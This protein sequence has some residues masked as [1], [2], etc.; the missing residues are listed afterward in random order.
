MTVPDGC[1]SQ[2]CH[3]YPSRSAR[4]GSWPHLPVFRHHSPSLSI[5]MSLKHEAIFIIIP[6]GTGIGRIF[7]RRPLAGL[8]CRPRSQPRRQR[9]TYT[10]T[11]TCTFSKP[12]FIIGQS[13]PVSTVL[14]SC[15]IKS[16]TDLIWL[17]WS[18]DKIWDYS[19][20]PNC[21]F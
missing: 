1:R 21:S 19:T 6:R 20:I 17:Q 8:H 7:H 11:Y 10:C 9:K 18:L 5:V 2:G 13:E 3:G 14:V 16:L 12:I 15:N 4:S